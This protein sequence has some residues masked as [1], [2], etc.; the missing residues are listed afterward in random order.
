MN[1][2][3]AALLLLLLSCTAFADNGVRVDNTAFDVF[4]QVDVA[5][6]PGAAD[7][8]VLLLADRPGRADRDLAVA[9]AAR[10]H[11]VA[12]V[13]PHR[14]LNAVARDHA[15]CIN[16]VTL[17][18]LLSQHLQ[19]QYRFAI[20]PAQLPGDHHFDGD[21]AAVADAILE[22]L[23]LAGRAGADGHRRGRSI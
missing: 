4:G 2:R 3:A 14:F 12:L 20:Q 21:A 10:S 8:I 19:A 22:P 11:L 9:L 15:A 13:R 7:D 1:R 18:D 23:T 17:L 5:H 16:L 6:R